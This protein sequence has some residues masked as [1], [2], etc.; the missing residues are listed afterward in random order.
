MSAFDDLLKTVPK[1]VARQIQQE[2]DINAR[3]I[4][5]LVRVL[6]TLVAAIKAQGPIEPSQHVKSELRKANRL[7]RVVT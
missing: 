4:N 1:D 7:L 6:S 5:D 2:L 3:L